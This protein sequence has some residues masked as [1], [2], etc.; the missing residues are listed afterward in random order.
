MLEPDATNFDEVPTCDFEIDDSSSEE[1]GI[2]SEP[3]G[4][5][6]G[7]GAF[8][9]ML[10]GISVPKLLDLEEETITVDFGLMLI[11]F[12]LTLI[13]AS[14]PGLPDVEEETVK[15]TTGVEC[16]GYGMFCIPGA[17]EVASSLNFDATI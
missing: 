14:V 9:L 15:S 10:I 13:G 11:H 2:R 7:V 4:V 1:M 3:A 16:C 8:D 17:S 5:I 12:G 6:T